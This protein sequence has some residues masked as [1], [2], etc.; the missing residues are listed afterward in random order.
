MT[1]EL[2]IIMLYSYR[3]YIVLL[4][5]LLLSFFLLSQLMIGLNEYMCGSFFEPQK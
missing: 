4:V 5:S 3:H 2:L 1:Y